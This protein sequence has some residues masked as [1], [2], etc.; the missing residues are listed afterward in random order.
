MKLLVDGGET[1]LSPLDRG[2]QYGDGVFRTL[3]LAAGEPVWWEDHLA[4]LAADAARLG[5][6]CP[7]AEVWRADLESLGERP[8]TGVL[9][10][11]LTRGV[12]ARGYRPAGAARPGRILMLDAAPIASD[13]WPDQGLAARVCAL[14]L[15]EQPALAGVKHLNRLENVLARAEWDDPA[16]H[17]GILLDQS[18]RVI[19][20]VM[21]NL[22]FWRDGRLHTPRLDRCGVAG[23]TRARLL[24]RF[25]AAAGEYRLEDL[26][27]AEEVMLCNSVMGLRRLSRLEHRHWPAPV[28]SP[29]LREKLHGPA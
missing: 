3:R 20:G 24:A 11:I 28:I 10:L 17:E 27:T 22:F 26:L 18:G 14:R 6:P 16:I 2:L 25:P 7:D 19:G 1:V 5:I 4:K 23:V 8:Q 9:K 15:G 13:A 21:S 29:L 12:G